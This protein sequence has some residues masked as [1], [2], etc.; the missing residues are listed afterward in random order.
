[1]AQN[2]GVGG[3][4]LWSISR[5]LARGLKDKTEYKSM[6]NHADQTRINDWDGRGNLST[7]ALQEYCE[8]FLSVA[9][10]Q[11]KFSASVF[12]FDTLEARY[13]KLIGDMIDDKRAPDIISAVLKHG[14]ID[15]GDVGFITKSPDRTA[16][17][18]LRT[19]LDHGFLKSA[20][21]KTPVRIAFPT[22]YRDRLFPNLFADGEMDAPEPSIPAFLHKAQIQAPPAPS[23]ADINAEVERRI[24]LLPDLQKLEGPKKVLGDVATK[25]LEEFGRAKANWKAVQER[26]I[27]E[28][29]GRFGRSRTEVIQTL[30]DYS[31]GAVTDEERAE[32]SQSVY[33]LAPGLV[34]KYDAN[35]RKP[36]R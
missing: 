21:A 15:R 31:P 8:W 9:L 17:N 25:E 6:M 33:D 16:R 26:V 34:K 10:D 1:M 24:A 28:S 35:L 5:G 13:R 32:V 30:H 14:S 2:A 29:I 11:I 4:G 7:K 20:S 18:T 22:A 27:K 19:L 23:V 36:K 12:A 3:K